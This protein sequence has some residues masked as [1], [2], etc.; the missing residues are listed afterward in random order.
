VQ[1]APGEGYAL[2]RDLMAGERGARRAALERL[3]AAPDPA[4]VPGLVDALFF[5]P[6]ELRGPLLEA[7]RLL[8]GESPG[9]GY[10]DWV[11]LVGRRHELAAGAGYPEW[12]LELFSRIDERYALVLDPAAP[13]RIR[14]EEIVWGGVGLEG[15]PALDDPPRIAA[16]EAAFLLDSERVFGITAGGAAHAYPL[17]YLSWHE[18]VNDSLGGEPITLSY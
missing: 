8:A 1:P 10:H 11:E 16:A 14:L 9:S 15:I 2:I 18:M 17:R 12:K 6:R 13:R 4:L 7:L 5:T 3:R